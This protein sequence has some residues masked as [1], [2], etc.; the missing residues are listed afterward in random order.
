MRALK[1]ANPSFEARM[2]QVLAASVWQ[3][4]HG[5]SR[6]HAINDRTRSFRD[7]GLVRK[8]HTSFEFILHLWSGKEAP[9]ALEIRAPRAAVSV[10]A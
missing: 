4:R 3:V 9:R 1:A 10:L 5:S 6:L 7:L 2:Q 8:A